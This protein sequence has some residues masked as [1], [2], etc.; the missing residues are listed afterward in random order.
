[1]IRLLVIEDHPVAVT[2]LRGMFR[3][4]RDGIEVSVC[5][6]SVDRVISDVRADG[7]DIIILDLHLFNTDPVHNVKILRHSFPGKPVVIFTSEE[8]DEWQR[9][10][11]DS[12]V[13]A[14]ILKTLSRKEIQGILGKVYHGKMVFSDF[15]NEHDINRITGLFE[16]GFFSITGNQRLILLDIS[17]GLTYKEIASKKNT[18]ISNIEKTMYH[19]RNKYGARNNAE[20][21]SILHNRQ[22]L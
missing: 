11:F 16:K 2:G 20:L 19:L 14:Y 12:G 17:Q 15:I 9:K 7:F 3:P 21:I 1:M 6:S 5:E 4:S 18:S 22:V 10:M 13:K 8:S